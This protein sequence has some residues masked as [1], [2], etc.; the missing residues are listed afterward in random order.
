V[1]TP[2]E[3]VVVAGRNAELKTRLEQIDRPIRHLA[4]GA[5]CTL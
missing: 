5:S 4:Q 1:E 3:L 2:L